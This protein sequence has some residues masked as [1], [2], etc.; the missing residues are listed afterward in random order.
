MTGLG[1]GRIVGSS[2][3]TRARSNPSIGYV[4][5]DVIDERRAIA[6][7]QILEDFPYLLERWR[8]DWFEAVGFRR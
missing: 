4:V 5:G 3:N 1:C 8:D 6:R 2:K 7:L